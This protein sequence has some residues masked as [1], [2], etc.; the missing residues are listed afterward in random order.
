MHLNK[1]LSIM[2]KNVCN[3]RR[4]FPPDTSI[5]YWLNRFLLAITWQ[6]MSKGPENESSLPCSW[7][8]RLLLIVDQPY[9]PE[10]M[11]KTIGPCS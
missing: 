3:L 7:H 2:L 9:K 1:K 10:E 5:D 8:N 6:E 11:R 4:L